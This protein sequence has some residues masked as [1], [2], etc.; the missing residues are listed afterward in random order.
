MPKKEYVTRRARLV[1][2]TTTDTMGIHSYTFDCEGS[3]NGGVES[4][5]PIVL[6]EKEGT[7]KIGTS[8]KIT[9]IVEE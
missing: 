4:G 6:L 8:Y 5:F 2:V 9:T 7:Y 3:W 1:T